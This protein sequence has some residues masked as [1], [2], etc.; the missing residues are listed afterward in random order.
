[1]P[2]ALETWPLAMF[3]RVLPRH[4]QIIYEINQRFLH[5]VMHRN[6]G[7]VELLRH[8]SIIDEDR[9]KR[10]RMAHL[11]IVGSHKVN[12]VAQIHTDLM[13]STTFADFEQTYPGKIINI[14]NGIT[15]RRWINQANPALSALIS[16]HIGEAWKTELEQLE[17]LVPLAENEAFRKAFMSVKQANKASLSGYIREHLNV[18][19][20]PDS[21]FD[22][23]IK[24]IHEYKRQL[25]NLLH[26]V[27]RYNRIRSGKTASVPVKPKGWC[28]ARSSLAARRHRV[29]RPPSSSSN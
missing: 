1:M 3:E 12:G 27:T 11:A 16:G 23:Q 6:P 7:D 2:E 25:L 29:T 18:Q 5:D 22:V 8:I 26:V 28:R 17:K 4:L 9:G 14:T 10:V 24:R 15:P 19:V 13:K 21:L 20:N